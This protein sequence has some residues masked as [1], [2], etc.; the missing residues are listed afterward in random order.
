MDLREQPTLDPSMDM[1]TSLGREATV[2]ETHEDPQAPDIERLEEEVRMGSW[3][4]TRLR[5][6]TV[7]WLT[8][9]FPSLYRPW[10]SR[11]LSL[12]RRYVQEA[13]SK[14][15]DCQRF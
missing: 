14:G 4:R 3:R 8:R 12:A 10:P 2:E 5:E 13:E 7:S 11:R 6:L 9:S 1:E 15:G